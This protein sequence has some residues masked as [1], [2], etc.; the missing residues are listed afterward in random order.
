MAR[1]LKADQKQLYRRIDRLVAKLREALLA[2]G[3]AMS[4]IADMLTHGADTL[5]IDF[6]GGKVPK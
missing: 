2:A 6:D 1:M 3:V 5:R 4:D